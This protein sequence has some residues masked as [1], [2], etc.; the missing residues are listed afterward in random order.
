MTNAQEHELKWL[1]GLLADSQDCV[2][3]LESNIRF[4]NDRVTS[5][6][7]EIT[8]LNQWIADLQ[9]G[10]YINCVYCGHRYEPGTPDVRDKVLYDHIKQCPKHPLSKAMEVVQGLA[11]LNWCIGYELTES[12]HEQLDAVRDMA[13]KLVREHGSD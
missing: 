13:I 4:L 1:R 11:D 5:Q 7:E 9:S 8:R 10:M 6:S 3:Q 12:Q 2:S